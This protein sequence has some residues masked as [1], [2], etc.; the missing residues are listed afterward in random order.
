MSNPLDQNGQNS[1]SGTPQQPNYDAYQY[2]S[3]P[4]SAAGT[5]YSGD[6]YPGYT[7]GAFPAGDTPGYGGYSAAPGG[8]AWAM[9]EEKNRVAPWALGVGILALLMGLS[10]VASG[11]AFVPGAIGIIV[12]AV[13]LLSARKLTG[14]GRRTGMAVTGIVLSVIAVGLSVLFWVMVTVFMSQTGMSECIELTDPDQQRE[15]VERSL[16]EWMAS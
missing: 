5:G 12:G 2:P 4:D 6:D 10:I 15:C 9:N 8:A 16:D 14:P 3:G 1:G 13:A 7:P 11:F